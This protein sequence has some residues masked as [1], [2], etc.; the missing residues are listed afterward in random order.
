MKTRRR[1]GDTELKRLIRRGDPADGEAPLTAREAAGIKQEILAAV[2][3]GRL[4]GSG[5]G[6]RWAA[7]VACVVILGLVGWSLRG[8]SAPTPDDEVAGVPSPRAEIEGLDADPVPS[9]RPI[10]ERS[11][12]EP[13]PVPAFRDSGEPAASS[14]GDPPPEDLQAR[15]VRF[16]T[17]RGT[18]IIWI[19]DPELEL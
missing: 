2:E 18:Q 17:R 9:T 19:L 1:D 6:W 7:A 3:D 8:P 13:P 11:T 12:P 4:A 14:V 10:E 16:T 5:A 15:T